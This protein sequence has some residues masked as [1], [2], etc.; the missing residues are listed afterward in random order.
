MLMLRYEIAPG[1]SKR[2]KKADG[3]A[4]AP[5]C[6]PVRTRKSLTFIQIHRGEGVRGG[7]ELYLDV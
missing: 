1:A 6:T 3:I 2:A 4:G 5:T 7:S